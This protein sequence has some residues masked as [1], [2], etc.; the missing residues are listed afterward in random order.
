MIKAIMHGI[1]NALYEE[2]GD[3]YQVCIDK[4]E[5]G[6]ENPCFFVSLVDFYNDELIMGREKWHAQYNIT[7]F[8]ENEDEP[9]D[10]CLEVIPKLKDLLR[11][12][13]LE[14]GDMVRGTDIDAKVVDG[15][16]QFY[17][18]YNFETI[19]DNS[20][21]KMQSYTERKGNGSK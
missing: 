12:V 19:N 5:Q 11:I 9:T 10:E 2:F 17:V 20:V 4:L 21:A 14:N 1:G 16:V 7:Y 18:S 15:Q 8:P 13:E 3:D 6:F